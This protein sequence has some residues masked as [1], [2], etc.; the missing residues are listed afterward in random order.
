M[1]ATLDDSPIGQQ[2]E[3]SRLFVLATLGDADAAQQLYSRCVPSLRAWLAVRVGWSLAEDAAH[4]AF[5]LAF[6]KSDRF[7]PG[8][9]FGAWLRTIAWNLAQKSLRDTARRQ[10]RELAYFEV[11]SMHTATTGDVNSA[12]QAALGRCLDALPERQ[13]GLIRSRYFDDQTCDAIAAA[14]GRT[15]VAVAVQ[16]HRIC[17]S[18]RSGIERLLPMND[19]SSTHS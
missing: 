2:D 4:D 7:R 5:V 1:K 18:L 19:I 14:Q 10:C 16:L 9:S 11:E 15:R 13:L 17:T 3:A 8:E 6:R 12:R